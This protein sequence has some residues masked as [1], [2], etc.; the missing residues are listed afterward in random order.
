MPHG[1]GLND[2]GLLLPVFL[3]YILSF[4]RRDLL[5]QSPSPAACLHLSDACNTLGQSPSALLVILISVRRGVDG[6]KPFHRSAHRTL[7]RGDIDGRD[8]ILSASAGNH[9]H[10]RGRV[11][12]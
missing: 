2:L 8:R 3:S 9:S 4:L 1:D 10:A 11:Q 12:F 7:W 6:G 5:D